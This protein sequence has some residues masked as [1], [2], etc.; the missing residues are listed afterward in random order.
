MFIVLSF[1]KKKKL[2][3]YARAIGG[4]GGRITYVDNDE[5]R[6]ASAPR[7]IYVQ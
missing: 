6:N 2:V 7:L 5:R 1:K 3:L 4:S